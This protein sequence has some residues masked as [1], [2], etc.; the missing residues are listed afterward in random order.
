MIGNLNNPLTCKN[1]AFSTPYSKKLI[2]LE[3]HIYVEVLT[4]DSL[5][6]DSY[7]RYKMLM[8][9]K[10]Y[11]TLSQFVDTNDTTTNQCTSTTPKSCSN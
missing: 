3:N 4:R 5:G 7:S 6:S 2:N 9:Y 8:P 10:S 11:E 1:E